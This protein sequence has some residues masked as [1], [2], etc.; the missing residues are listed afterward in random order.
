MLNPTTC[1]R[2]W[3]EGEWRQGLERCVLSL[4]CFSPAFFLF[5]T[6]YL[7]ETP[8]LHVTTA[9][10]GYITAKNEQSVKDL[11]GSGGSGS[12]S[13]IPTT[14][15]KGLR[16]ALIKKNIFQVRLLISLTTFYLQT[17]TTTI[18]A[19]DWARDASRAEVSFFFASFFLL[20]IFYL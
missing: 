14:T 4:L 20:T 1:N 12:P 19:P 13:Q 5:T 3:D 15:Q 16:R 2:W 11:Q 17:A 18:L 6:N 10:L 8:S 7:L 9:T